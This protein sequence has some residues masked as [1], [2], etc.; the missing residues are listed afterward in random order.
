MGAAV[1]QDHARFPRPIFVEAVVK[2]TSLLRQH[3][4]I[5]HLYNILKL[6]SVW[7][8]DAAHSP[9][10]RHNLALGCDLRDAVTIKSLV[11]GRLSECKPSCL[12]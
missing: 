10:S 5:E 3:R 2:G 8:K 12:S 9:V 6:A 4:K 7:L 1:V 11:D